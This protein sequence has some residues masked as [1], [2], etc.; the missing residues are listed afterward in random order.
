[1]QHGTIKPAIVELNGEVMKRF[2]LI[3]CC[4][5]IPGLCFAASKKKVTQEP[6]EM[7]QTYIDSLR[8]NSEQLIKTYRNLELNDLKMRNQRKLENLELDYRGKIPKEVTESGKKLEDEEK[9]FNTSKTKLE[10]AR[11]DLKMDAMKYYKGKLPKWLKDEWM[12]E[13]IKSSSE[14]QTILEKGNQ[15]RRK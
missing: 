4:L 10:Q 2:F 9:D 11:K 6:D 3:I 7:Q 15:E 13:E 1:L 12:Q 8:D 14:I 5:L